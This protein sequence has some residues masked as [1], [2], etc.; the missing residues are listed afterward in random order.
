MAYIL[1]YSTYICTRCWLHTYKVIP[2]TRRAALRRLLRYCWRSG[3]IS[4]K[5]VA[6]VKYR[7]KQLMRLRLQMANVGFIG[8]GWMGAAMARHT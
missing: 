5:V 1:C 6:Y 7:Y 4:N 8:P 2:A 3:G